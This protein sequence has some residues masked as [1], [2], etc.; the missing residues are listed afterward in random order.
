MPLDK[1]REHA[2]LRKK[3]SRTLL[4]RKTLLAEHSNNLQHQIAL[5][6]NIL[7][8]S[9]KKSNFISLSLKERH[10]LTES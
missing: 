1:I 9:M 5:N 6:I 3:G 7:K 8:N 4:V 2:S 10:H